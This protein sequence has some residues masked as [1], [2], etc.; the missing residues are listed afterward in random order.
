MVH[1]LGSLI[2]DGKLKIGAT[3]FHLSQAHGVRDAT[4]TVIA[5]GLLMN[6]QTYLTPTPSAAEAIIRRSTV[7]APGICPMTSLSPSLRLRHRMTGRT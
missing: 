6:R 1:D 3:L 2:K 5:D 7:K 4:A